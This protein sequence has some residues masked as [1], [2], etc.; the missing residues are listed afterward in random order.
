M[1]DEYN[2]PG[3]LNSGVDQ[4]FLQDFLSR[5]QLSA[6]IESEK[7]GAINSVYGGGRIGYGFPIDN[8]LLSLGLLGSGYKVSGSTPEGSFKQSDIGLRG[9]DISY[10]YGPNEVGASY[11]KQPSIGDIINLFYRRSF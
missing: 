11:E 2:I 7:Q 1:G 3:L 8:N 10:M 6:N 4:S 9:G 5:L